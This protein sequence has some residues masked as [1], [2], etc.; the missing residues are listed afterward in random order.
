MHFRILI[1]E[2]SCTNRTYYV[3][4]SLPDL[5]ISVCWVFSHC[6]CLTF[7]MNYVLDLFARTRNK[8]LLMHPVDSQF[9]DQAV[10][11]TPVTMLYVLTDLWKSTLSTTLLKYNSV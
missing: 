10:I 11:S 3:F 8:L 1:P 7:N 4:P 6:L 9:H 2:L 5:Y